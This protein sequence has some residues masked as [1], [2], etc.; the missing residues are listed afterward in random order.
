MEKLQNN[1]IEELEKN[2]KQLLEQAEELYNQI[3]RKY[4]EL[5]SDDPE[6]DLSEEVGQLNDL[7]MQIVYVSERI[8]A[9]KNGWICMDCGAQVS[10]NDRF[11]PNCGKQI[12]RKEDLDETEAMKCPRCGECYEE[13]QKFCSKCGFSLTKQEIEKEYDEKIELQKHTCPN[14]GADI[15]DDMKFCIICGQK[16]F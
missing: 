2:R 15:D 10:E 5:H 7:H 14:C 11:C 9:Y 4:Y 8:E 3:G 16:L 12:I 6:E 13:N 1:K